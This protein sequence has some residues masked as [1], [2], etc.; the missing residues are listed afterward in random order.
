MLDATLRLNDEGAFHWGERGLRWAGGKMENHGWPAPERPDRSPCVSARWFGAHRR[1]GP[2]WDSIGESV[3]RL[4]LDP[5]DRGGRMSGVALS[6]ACLGIWSG[7]AVADESAPRFT[8]LHTND[9]QSRLL[10]YGPNAEYSPQTPNDDDTVGGMARLASLIAQR[11]AG[12][13][14]PQLLLDGGDVTCL[15]GLSFLN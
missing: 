15:R 6:L 7:V 13:S 9:W 1:L 14:G 12:I 8:I 10:G 11:Q 4:G 2:G 5:G 3:S